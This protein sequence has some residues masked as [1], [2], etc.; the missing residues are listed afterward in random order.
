MSGA[1]EGGRPDAVET[2][3]ARPSV[4]PFAPT[5]LALLNVLSGVR[6]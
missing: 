1:I 4:A 6:S 3:K 5:L 2:F